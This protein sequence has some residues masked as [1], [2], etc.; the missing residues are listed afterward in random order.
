MQILYFSPHLDDVVF[1]CGAKILQQIEEGHQVNIW[2]LFAGDPPLGQISDFAL[3]LHQRWGFKDAVVSKRREEDKIACRILEASFHHWDYPDCIYRM[4]SVTKKYLYTSGKDI[5]GNYLGKEEELIEDL[6]RKIKEKITKDTIMISPLGIGN[7]IDHQIC[8][9]I[10]EKIR[11]PEYYYLDFP[12]I[13]KITE[14]VQSI[15][16][17]KY[18]KKTYPVTPDEIN[19]WQLSIEAYSSQLSSFWE[20]TN[21]MRENIQNYVDS[22]GGISLISKL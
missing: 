15:I 20:N 17:K 12:Y 5:F 9:K 21:K 7:H 3:E 1:S 6:A 2:T 18:R 11:K 16:P 10:I 4:D 14:S 22:I 19:K 8:R 13:E